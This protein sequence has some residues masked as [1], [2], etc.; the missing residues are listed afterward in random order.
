MRTGSDDTSFH[1]NPRSLFQPLFS[2]VMTALTGMIQR[3]GAVVCPLN[4]R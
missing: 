1:K 3:R 4:F 2:Q